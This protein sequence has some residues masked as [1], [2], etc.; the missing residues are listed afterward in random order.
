MVKSLT[1]VDMALIDSATMP[2]IFAKM[3]GDK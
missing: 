2:R 3:Q 1:L